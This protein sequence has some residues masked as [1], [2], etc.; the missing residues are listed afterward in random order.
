MSPS[1]FERLESVCDVHLTS[2]IQEVVIF[3]NRH[4]LILP[5]WVFT[6]I[7]NALSLY[8]L[9]L[10]N[11]IIF[12]NLRIL[13]SLSGHIEIF[14][15][16]LPTPVVSI[17]HTSLLIRKQNNSFHQSEQT[18][19]LLLTSPLTCFLETVWS[20]ILHAHSSSYENC[21]CDHFWMWIIWESIMMN[22]SPSRLKRNI[23]RWSDCSAIWILILHKTFRKIVI[24]KK[25]RWIIRQSVPCRQ[26]CINDQTT[27]FCTKC[28]SF[29]FILVSN[30]CVFR[31]CCITFFW[32]SSSIL[33]ALHVHRMRFSFLSLMLKHLL[34]LIQSYTRSTASFWMFARQVLTVS[35]RENWPLFVS[36][37]RNVLLKYSKFLFDKSYKYSKRNLDHDDLTNC[38]Q[39]D[40]IPRWSVLCKAN[41]SYKYW[42]ILQRNWF[43]S[44]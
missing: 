9:I 12:V 23:R 32:S 24:R 39:H 36:S 37:D 19:H 5:S 16:L 17:I 43:T 6:G 33:T 15:D 28:H 40:F 3:V 4:D 11:V 2:E 25:K 14:S 20:R 41:V 21:L 29:F 27:P 8:S 38:S 34:T 35:Q 18:F 31:S 22:P 7:I 26:V 44:W 10:F 1:H 30:I 13:S 42:S